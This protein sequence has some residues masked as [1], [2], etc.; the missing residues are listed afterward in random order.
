MLVLQMYI[1]HGKFQTIGL[2][3]ISTCWCGP[4]VG[5]SNSTQFWS[6]N[7]NGT[8]LVHSVFDKDLSHMIAKTVVSSIRIIVV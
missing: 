4:V 2:I 3:G 1:M 6:S 8:C 5:T 7:Q